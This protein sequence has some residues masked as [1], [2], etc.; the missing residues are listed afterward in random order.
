[1]AA[2]ALSQPSRASCAECSR[3]LLFQLNPSPRP[4]MGIPICSNM[5]CSPKRAGHLHELKIRTALPRPVSAQRQAKGRRAFAL[6]VAGVDDDQ[7]PALALGSFVAFF[8]GAVSICMGFL[9]QV[10]FQERAGAAGQ[11]LMF[12]L[13][14]DNPVI[15]HCLQRAVVAGSCAAPWCCRR[16]PAS[17]AASSACSAIDSSCNTLTTVQPLRHQ[18]AH[19][20]QPVGLVG[21]VEVGQGSS[22]SSTGGVHG[23][24]ARQQH[25]L[26]LAAESWPSGRSRQ[27]QACVAQRG[28]GGGV[29]GR[30]GRLQPALVRQAAEQAT[31]STVRSSAAASFWPSQPSGGRVRAGQSDRNGPPKSPARSAPPAASQHLEQRGLA[32]TVGADD[33]G[34]AAVPEHRA[35]CRAIWSV[36]RCQRNSWAH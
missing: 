9:K 20:Q 36:F 6:A 12:H 3:S 8:G 14:D 15:E 32:R 5:R 7:G 23:Q 19:Q 33:A 11:P 29:V 31:S 30:A 2:R 22:I 17:T 27:A 18:A 35:K 24:G 4:S 16:P 21:R 1:M 25:A 28:L 26:A 34:P 10:G 13:P